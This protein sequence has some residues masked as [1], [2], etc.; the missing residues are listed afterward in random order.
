MYSITNI[1]YSILLR[2]SELLQYI[3]L[4]WDASNITVHYE[5]LKSLST[6]LVNV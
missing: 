1:Y 4:Q 6:F 2:C 5:K 3:Y